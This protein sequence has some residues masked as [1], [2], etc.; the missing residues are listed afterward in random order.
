MGKHLR[1]DDLALR[2][3]KKRKKKSRKEA[4]KLE[5]NPHTHKLLALSLM[6]VGYTTEAITEFRTAELQGEEDDNIHYYLGVLL[7]RINMK[8]Q[9]IE[10]LKTFAIS[11]TCL[12]IDNRCEDAR[13]RVAKGIGE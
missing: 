8:A 7:E 10:E 11:E 6:E 3:E 13:Q 5:D 2:S 12:Q 4:L 1:D 9:S